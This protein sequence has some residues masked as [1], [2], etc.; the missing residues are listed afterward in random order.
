MAVNSFKIRNRYVSDKEFANIQQR[1]NEGKTVQQTLT[2]NC[3]SPS[4]ADQKSVVPAKTDENFELI[5][6]TNTMAASKSDKVCEKAKERS[7]IPYKEMVCLHDKLEGVC[8]NPI[9][10]KEVGGAINWVELV[11]LS[12]NK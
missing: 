7:K 2:N 1:K 6:V 3:K 10:E 8:T 9:V 5:E 12:G 11:T 4:S